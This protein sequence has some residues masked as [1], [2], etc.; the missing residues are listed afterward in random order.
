MLASSPESP[1]KRFSARPFGY[2][3]YM[4]RTI[5]AMPLRN[6]TPD[7]PA[8]RAPLLIVAGIALALVAL[9]FFATL[10]SMNAK[11]GALQQMTGMLEHMDRSLSQTNQELERANRALVLANQRL[12]VSVSAGTEANVR[13]G[14]TN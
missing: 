4:A 3:A 1:L 13:L 8:M 9:A 6:D 10:L 14:R 5:L 11:L 7:V 12:A 2:I